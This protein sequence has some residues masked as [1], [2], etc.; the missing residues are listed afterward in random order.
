MFAHAAM[1]Y[2]NITGMKDYA[3]D[4]EARAISSWNWYQQ[5][6][7]DGTRNSNIDVTSPASTSVMS[8]DA[9]LTVE[10]QDAHAV[11]AAVY[12]FALTGN[13]TYSDYIIN[14]YNNSF[15]MQFS[16]DDPHSQYWGFYTGSAYDNDQR[17]A[18]LFYTT[19]P[20]ADPSVKNAILTKIGDHAESNSSN[21]FIWDSNLNPYRA[22]VP[23]KLYHWGSNNPICTLGDHLSDL[24]KY[25]INPSQ[26]SDYKKR[27]VNILHY[28]NGVNPLNM[29]LLTNMGSY[30]AEKSAMCMYHEWF[31][32]NSAWDH[33]CAPGYMPGGVNLLDYY[34][35]DAFIKAQPDMK[36][37]KDGYFNQDYSITEPMCNYQATYVE[38]VASFVGKS[39]GSAP[40]IESIPEPTTIVS[41]SP[42]SIKTSINQA[43]TLPA[44]VSIIYSNNTTDTVP[45]TWGSINPASYAHEGTFTVNGSIEFA[46]IPAVANITV[47]PY[48]IGIVNGSS[49][50]SG[51]ATGSAFD[52]DTATYYQ[53]S[54][55]SNNRY[56]GMDLGAGNEKV[57]RKVKYYS[58][59][60]YESALNN[61]QIQGSN[62]SAS[63]GFT[64]LYTLPASTTSGWKIGR[65]HV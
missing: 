33:N 4:L 10:Q 48:L 34:G 32:E 13:S 57:I 61:A 43:P 40:A 55:T 36:A 59:P 28:I 46:T 60:S 30:G 12:L 3:T 39:S 18:L 31:R 5:Q 38:L 54:S 15:V 1:V 45:V 6:V 16:G 63:S 23:G 21:Q 9:D 56:V 24:V 41:I 51:H 2:K 35:N 42:V 27:A 64:T 65:A 52:D 8:G 49:A 47:K 50:A 29:T 44:T 14:H 58:T 19:L 37:Y 26:Q 20:N 22:Y 11:I 17:A 62:T 7:A 53:S 25:N